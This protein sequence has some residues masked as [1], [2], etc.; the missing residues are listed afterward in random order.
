MK[1]LILLL[2][3][4]SQCATLFAQNSPDADAEKYVINDSV[5]IKTPSGN[6]LSAVVVRRRDVAG[7]QPAALLFF[8]YSDTKRSLM[9]AQYAADHGYV[10]IVADVRG[11]RLSPDEVTPYEHDAEDVYWVID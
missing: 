1:K 7:P 2:A 11:K 6:T 8:I 9:E 4:V 3:F 10:G 5:L